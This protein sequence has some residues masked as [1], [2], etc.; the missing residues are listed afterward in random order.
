MR[1]IEKNRSDGKKLK[2]ISLICNMNHKENHLVER[3][4]HSKKSSCI[5]NNKYVS[6]RRTELTEL[7]SNHQRINQSLK[8]NWM[9][10]NKMLNYRFF[11]SSW[12]FEIFSKTE[13]KT[14]ISVFDCSAINVDIYG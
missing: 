8:K 1:R 10:M 13:F 7:N 14:T 12:L 9:N 5:C 6:R 11:S 4:F 3:Y 2:E